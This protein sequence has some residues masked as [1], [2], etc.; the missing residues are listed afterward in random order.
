LH[1]EQ[2]DVLTRV[3]A[4]GRRSH[5]FFTPAQ[6]A[7]DLLGARDAIGCWSRMTYGF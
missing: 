2:R 5:R 6:N 7:E 4:Q 3:D 1:G